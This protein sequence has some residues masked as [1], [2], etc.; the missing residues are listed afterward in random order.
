MG[1]EYLA[2]VLRAGD[3]RID[4]LLSGFAWGDGRITY[5]N[6]DAA[7]DYGSGYRQRL[8]RRWPVG[9][10]RELRAA[11]LGAVRFGV[12]AALDCVSRPSAGFSV[13]GFTTLAVTFAGAGSGAGDI[14]VANTADA[15]TAYAFF[16]GAAWAAMSG[17]AAPGACRGPG[18]TINLT[19][20]HELGHALGL[21]HSHENWG[22][23]AVPLEYDTPEFT[24]MTYRP[25]AGGSAT[26]LRFEA[27]GAPQSYMMLDIAA[28]Q[29]MYGAD[30]R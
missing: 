1:D 29:D 18:T 4:G 27:W 3:V 8:R 13:E 26:G 15:P 22:L 19:I 9:P 7:V 11:F 6:P 28:L 5:S 21:K 17:W 30:T 23:G 16:P 12:R 10:A 25:F 14:R 2:S 24:V 20:L